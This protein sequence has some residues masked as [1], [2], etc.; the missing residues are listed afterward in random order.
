MGVVPDYAALAAS[1]VEA[2][3]EH[4]LDEIEALLGDTVCY[5]CS[6]VGSYSGIVDII[7][8]MA[9]FFSNFPNVK[10]QVSRYDM[11]APLSISFEFRMTATYAETGAEI[12]R[13]GLERID[14]KKD[15]KIIH[16]AVG[17]RG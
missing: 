8:M 15:G 2:S 6:N 14:F 17:P 4:D 5:T 3:N 16:I 9:G 12:E 13:L 1:Y 10:W 7:Q 11:T